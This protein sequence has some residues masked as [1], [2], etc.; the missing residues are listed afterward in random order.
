MDIHLPHPSQAAAR[1]PFGFFICAAD[2]EIL[3]VFNDM[4]K[5]VIRGTAPVAGTDGRRAVPGGAGRTDHLAEGAVF[6][7]FPARLDDKAGETPVQDGIKG[8]YVS[9]VIAFWGHAARRI[10][11]V[12]VIGA[13]ENVRCGAVTGNEPV[14]PIK[15]VIF[16]LPVKSQEQAA[17]GP[18]PELMELL[19]KSSFGRRSRAAAKICVKFLA[20]AFPPPW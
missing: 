20:D 15:K 13:A 7:V 5:I 10:K 1:D 16:Q 8:V 18:V 19:I 2:Q 9:L 6:I 12:R 14:F 4:H 11:S 17:Q 3:A